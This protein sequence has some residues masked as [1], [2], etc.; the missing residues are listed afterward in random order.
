MKTLAL[1]LPA[2][3]MGGA[4]KIAL[5]FLPALCA[6]YKVT[7]VLSKKEGE[8][9]SKLPPDIEVVEDRLLE[10]REIFRADLKGFKI[11]KIFKDLVYYFRV[12]TKK[13]T[14]R[15]H[16]YIVGR[17]PALK[18]TFDVAICYVANVS[19]QIFSALDRTEADTK[20][21]WIHGETTE[22]K[23]AELYE[24]CYSEF[25]KIFAVSE[26]SRK[27]FAERFP[28]L[29]KKCAV[30][31][32]PIDRD[33]IIDGAAKAPDVEFN[34]DEINIV[35]VGRLTPEKG[36]DMIPEVAKIL[37]E[38]GHRVKFYI[39]GG[40]PM[41]DSVMEKST[42]LGIRDAVV[43]LGVKTNPYPY[44]KA[45]DIYIQPSYEEGYSTTIC[46]AGT[47]GC[48]IVGTTTS[49][50]IREQV[51]DEVSALLAEPTPESL[52]KKIEALINDPTLA[53]KLKENVLKKDFSNKDEIYKLL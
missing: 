41:A 9:L 29:D 42:E 14:D 22:L 4:E 50:G 3:R 15:D 27:H 45:S 44:M 46:E 8:L 24:G 16:R 40:G 5:N 1:L 28:S 53:E 25:D 30:Y 39:I 19:T 49:G 23:D 7:V 31:Y 34:K 37:L 36:Y 51:E 20:I 12:K 35:S 52:A 33:S 17:T 26:M 13:N 6:H 43:L 48:A 21:A 2:M 32:N 10:F 11:A 18:R 47:L 38:R